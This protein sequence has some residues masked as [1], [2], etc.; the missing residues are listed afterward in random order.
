[1]PFFIIHIILDIS[2]SDNSGLTSGGTIYFQTSDKNKISASTYR[3]TCTMI[4]NGMLK[5]VEMG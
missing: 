3:N 2:Y 1:M 5:N 4:T